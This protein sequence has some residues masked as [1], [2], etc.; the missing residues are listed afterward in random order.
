[1]TRIDLAKRVSARRGKP[2]ALANIH[3]DAGAGERP[4]RAL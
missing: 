4:V 2:I 3:D 1:M